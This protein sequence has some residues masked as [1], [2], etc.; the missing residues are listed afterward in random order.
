MEKE[1]SKTITIRDIPVELWSQVRSKSILEGK[2]TKQVV[3]EL[4][5]EYV[6]KRG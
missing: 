6:K 2:A 4:F 3:I 5:R 1:E